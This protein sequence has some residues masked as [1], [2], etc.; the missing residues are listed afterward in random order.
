MGEVHPSFRFEAFDVIAGVFSAGVLQINV[1]YVRQR[2][3]PGKDISKFLLF[4]FLV[5]R[6]EGGGKFSDLFDKPH[7]RGGDASLPVSL[8]VF[9][10]NYPL[11]FAN[12]HFISS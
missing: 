5:I 11:K 10:R 3:E 6:C 4:I 9:L 7:K 8:F 2:A 12:M 1:A